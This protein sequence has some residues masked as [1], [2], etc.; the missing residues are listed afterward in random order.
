MKTGLNW[1]KILL[2][3]GFI[4]MLIGIIDPLEG[5]VVIL[6]GSFIVAVAAFLGKSRQRLIIYSAFGLIASGVALLFWISSLGGVGGDTGRSYWWLLVVLPY[7]VGYVF[8]IIGS[9]RMMRDRSKK[10]KSEE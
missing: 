6:A 8:G 9:V 10:V 3:V 1:P 4:A 7:P 5:S 2:I